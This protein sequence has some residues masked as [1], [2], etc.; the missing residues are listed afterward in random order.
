MPK[1]AMPTEIKVAELGNF[2]KEKQRSLLK[3][4]QNAIEIGKRLTLMKTKLPHGKWKI[5]LSANFDFS[6]R[7]AA[8]FMQMSNRF[9]KVQTSATLN[10]SQMAE[11]LAL[12]ESE[13]EKFIAVNE[14]A[15]KPVEKMTIRTLRAKI[16]KYNAELVAENNANNGAVDLNSAAEEVASL[17]AE[18]T[19]APLNQEEENASVC[20]FDGNVCTFSNE[21]PG[22]EE[23]TEKFATEKLMQFLKLLPLLLNKADLLEIISN[24]APQDLK[25]LERF[26]IQLE[27]VHLELKNQLAAVH[28]KVRNCLENLKRNRASEELRAQVKNC[29]ENLKSKRAEMTREE[30]IA[31]LQKVALADEPPFKKSKFIRDAVQALGFKSVQRVPTEELVKILQQVTTL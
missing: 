2:T 4:G 21:P 9:S 27:I 6:Y 28:T 23:A 29:L 30:V 8:Q 15:G 26:V 16:K 24:C 31:A 7:A 13:T 10:Y 25:N 1:K 12:P 20:T 22:Q 18:E 11:M 19:V 14:A 3:S 17:A 5:W